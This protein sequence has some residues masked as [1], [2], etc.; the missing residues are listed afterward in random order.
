MHGVATHVASEFCVCYPLLNNH[1]SPP[2]SLLLLCLPTALHAAPTPDQILNCHDCGLMPTAGRALAHVPSPC[3][4]STFLT[5]VIAYSR[6]ND[7]QVTA[8]P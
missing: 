8:S 6:C 7:S 3:F 4:L 2:P 1:V 5:F